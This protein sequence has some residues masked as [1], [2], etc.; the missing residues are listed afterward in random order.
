MLSTSRRTL[1]S[2]D[3]PR[4]EVLKLIGLAAVVAVLL[5]WVPWL[6]ALAFPFRLLLT[7]V[8]ELGHGLA[9]LL[10]GGEFQRFWIAPDGSGLAYT[11]G[12]W[13]W[14][15]V[16]AG[17]LG[18][19]LFGAVLVLLGRRPRAGRFALIAIGGA[20]VLLTVRYGVPNL[21]SGDLGAGLL[22]VVAGCGIGL[23]LLFVGLRTSAR[24]VVFTVHLIAIEAALFALDDLRVLVGLSTGLGGANDARS[25]A[26][27]TWIPA[28]VWAL[29][30][31]AVAGAMI[32]F[33]VYRAWLRR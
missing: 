3:L 10:T 8:H 32:G 7:T 27:M 20:M 30:W 33:A 14:L 9:A 31:G 29:L 26:E 13:R 11:A 24:W 5:A 22:T 4:A 12:G 1:P 6:S 23:L 16:P 19:A 17:Y 18:A 25:M 21:L 15:I 28:V 2:R